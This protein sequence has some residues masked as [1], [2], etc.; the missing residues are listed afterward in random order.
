MPRR[1][2]RAVISGSCELC[3]AHCRSAASSRPQLL[4]GRL[5]H[6]PV[7]EQTLEVG[8]ETDRLHYDRPG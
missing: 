8:L 1:T 2:R 7:P 4:M 5:L 6:R 3:S